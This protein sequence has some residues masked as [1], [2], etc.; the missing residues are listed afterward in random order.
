MELVNRAGDKHRDATEA[1]V[2]GL[3]PGEALEF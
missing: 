3:L 1:F 2:A